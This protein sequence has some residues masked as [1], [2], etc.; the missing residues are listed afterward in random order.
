MLT[1]FCSYGAVA[2]RRQGEL[3]K[4]LAEP[5]HSEQPDPEAIARAVARELRRSEPLG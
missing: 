3:I 1:T 5:K 4:E 2:L